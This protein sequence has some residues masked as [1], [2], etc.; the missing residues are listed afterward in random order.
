[1]RVNWIPSKPINHGRVEELLKEC[2]KSNQYTNY[3]PVVR[4]LE[5]FIREKFEIDDDRAVVV[6]SNATIGL[7]VVASAIDI[8]TSKDIK[9]ATQSYTF[10]SSAQVK[11]GRVRIVDIDEEGGID[12]E[13][14]ILNEVDGLFVSNIFGNVCNIDKYE[15]Y[16]E[17]KNKALVLDNAATPYTM[18]SGKNANN[19]GMASVV[20]F[21]HTKMGGFG[22]GGA[23]FTTRRMEPIVRRL[24][25]FGIDNSSFNPKWEPTGCN[26]K[27]SDIS[28]SYILSYLEDNFDSMCKHNRYLYVL[29]SS[30]LSKFGD[31]VRLFPNFGGTPVCSCICVIFRKNTDRLVEMMKNSGFYTRKYYTP[32]DNSTRANRMYDRILCL[33]CHSHVTQ[34]IVREY[35]EI[36]GNFLNES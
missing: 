17:K 31:S 9:W 13:D 34:D 35:I 20:S 15:L 33:P 27:A 22:E 3:G 8:L 30:E 7:G 14:P 18:F 25:N 19:F 4:K 29:F 11:N 1:M 21:H 6:V 16:C 2:E 32:L 23:I 12:L 24:I 28:A 5:S 26:G 36:I 10:P